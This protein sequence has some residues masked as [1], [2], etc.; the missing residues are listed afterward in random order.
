MCV[1]VEDVNHQCMEIHDVHDY[2]N[3]RD[4]STTLMLTKL[5][6]NTFIFAKVIS[7]DEIS[8]NVTIHGITH[9]S[10]SIVLVC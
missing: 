9:N 6:L 7:L 10:I 3:A 4:E 1:H 8:Q 2:V 5:S